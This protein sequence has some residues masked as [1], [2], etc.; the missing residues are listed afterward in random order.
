MRH[1]G[2]EERVGLASSELAALV[3]RSVAAA[4]SRLRAELEVAM[5]SRVDELHCRLVEQEA[6]ISQLVDSSKEI[7]ETSCQVMRTLHG[8]L[9]ARGAEQEKDRR[10]VDALER[11]LLA[12]AEEL[13]AW[14][15]S[16]E[17]AAAAA[18]VG[19]D[20]AAD[21]VADLDSIQRRLG[22]VEVQL[23]RYAADT[24]RTPGGPPIADEATPAAAVT[25]AAA[26]DAGSPQLNERS[27]A[28]SP[29]AD[30]R[31]QHG[32]IEQSP[33]L[34]LRSGS[35][36][37]AAPSTAGADTLWSDTNGLEGDAYR[38]FWAVATEKVEAAATA[39]ATLSVQ[40]GRAE[41]SDA[42]RRETDEL[43]T[44]VVT[45][46]TGCRTELKRLADAFGVMRSRRHNSDQ[47]VRSLAQ[48]L[49]AMEK[50]VSLSLTLSLT[51]SVS[52]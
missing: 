47:A 7:Y 21:A 12:Q 9:T 41:A 5:A 4:E 34:Q 27:S 51:L 33:R 30:H 37:E 11:R 28:L 42:V 14:I 40:E 17:A 25:A 45:L 8:A 32:P 36:S 22:A 38:Q 20:D 6:T 23:E 43:A 29:G 2:M 46:L 24:R 18:R 35:G 13:A 10:R 44:L 1:A 19:C 50:Q 31:H 3:E 15:P 26:L 39:A 16:H 48:K 49:Q 52:L